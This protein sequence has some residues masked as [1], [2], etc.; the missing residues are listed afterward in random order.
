[1]IFRH[2]LNN[3][4]KSLIEL[5]KTERLWHFPFLAG[6]CIGI[7]LFFGWYFEKPAYGNIAS[8]GALVILY[9]T[10]A[11]LAKR[12]I[13]LCVCAF[14]FT[15]AFALGSVFSFNPYVSALALG[16]IAFLSHLV[17]SY[18]D[19][20]PP[21]NFFFIM[22]GAVAISLPFEVEAIPVRIGLVSMGAMISVL[23][24][25]I[26]SVL[27]AKKA[28]VPR[29]RIAQK[30]KR[31]TRIVESLIL[32]LAMFLALLIA[33]FLEVE[34]PYWIPI[35]ALSIMQ[36]K[37]L[38]HTRQRNLHR[39]FGTFIGM[40]LTWAILILEPRGL[41]LVFII[42]GLQFLVELIIV[43]NYGLAVIFITPLTIF[44]AENSAGIH[45]NIN[46]LMEARILDTVIGSLIGLG[47]GWFLHHQNLVSS[48]EKRIRGT[49]LKVKRY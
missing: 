5:K 48:L 42:A 22:I 23:L 37:D 24:A 43:R 4:V 31:Y 38:L 28:E 1:M 29:T 14:G 30:K 26:Y 32:A 7:C 46:V 21:R 18:F 45:F 20:P 40:G 34:S 49:K 41:A 16:F 2:Q 15:L 27:I 35:S 25:F 3:H 11:P 44:L 8:M 17:T 12:M 39:I 9:F 33:H 19:V 6:T 10:Q 13:H 47:A 36:G